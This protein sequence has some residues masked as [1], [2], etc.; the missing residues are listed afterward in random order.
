MKN[1][2]FKYNI[3]H[4]W[5]IP[6]YPDTEMEVYAEGIL[7]R[8]DPEKYLPEKT[9]I[10]F[11]DLLVIHCDSEFH[12]PA[13]VFVMKNREL[14]KNFYQD[15]YVVLFSTASADTVEHI[16]FQLQKQFNFYILKKIEKEYLLMLSAVGILPKNPE[17]LPKIRQ[18]RRLCKSLRK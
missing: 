1:V 15:P 13:L 17:V 5:W 12:V 18:S 16:C 9:E 11:K 8:R 10:L 4:A 6:G 14:Q 2:L 3:P 7:L